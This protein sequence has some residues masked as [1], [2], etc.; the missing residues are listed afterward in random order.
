MSA[1]AHR[2]YKQ[3]ILS[4]HASDTLHTKLYDVGWPDAA[5]RVI[6]TPLI[7]EWERV[8]RPESGHRPREGETT[9]LLKRDD[10]DVAIVNYS[11]TPPAESFEG[12]IGG[13]ALYAG[14]SVS[15]VKEIAPAGE[16]VRAIAREAID[17]IASRLAPLAR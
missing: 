16:I 14:Q 4:A 7:D 5:H 10:L 2:E 9:G 1:G 3:A 13:L 12:D 6:R 15:L 8:G 11:V 17:A